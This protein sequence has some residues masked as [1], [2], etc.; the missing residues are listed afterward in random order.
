MRTREL[1]ALASSVSLFAAVALAGTASAQSTPNQSSGTTS[2]PAA[3]G[4]ATMGSS[5]GSSVETKHQSEAVG[6]QSR[7]VRPEDSGGQS[8][9]SQPPQGPEAGPSDDKTGKEKQ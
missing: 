9:S 5:S 7:S 3:G 8:G 4:P 1:L 2:G 6:T